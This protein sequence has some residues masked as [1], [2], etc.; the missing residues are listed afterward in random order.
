MITNS[1]PWQLRQRAEEV[2]AGGAAACDVPHGDLR[3]L[4]QELQLHQIELELQNEALREAQIETDAL[5]QRYFELFEHS[6]VAYLDLTDDARILEANRAAANLLGETR[7]ELV[8]QR[9]S[10]FIDAACAL[11]FARYQRGM[12]A[13]DAPQAC[14][15]DIVRADGARRTV[16]IESVR[17]SSGAGRRWR[18]ALIDITQARRVERE[19]RVVQQLEAAG[20]LATA[21][22]HDFDESVSAIAALAQCAL[23][24][25]RAGEGAAGTLERLL[26]AAH[27]AGDFVTQLRVL[28]SNDAGDTASELDRSV[29]RPAA[30]PQAAR[31]G[32]QLQEVTPAMPWP[33]EVPAPGCSTI[34][35]VEDEALIRLTIRNYLEA[36]GHR[37]LEAD[38]MEQAAALLGSTRGGIDLLMS[39]LLLGKSVCGPEL[40][41]TALRLNPKTAVLFMSAHPMRELFKRGWVQVGTP[42][43][44]KPFTRAQLETAVRV[45]LKHP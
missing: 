2:L 19:L 18:A 26:Q 37:V 42:V 12:L 14:E 1:K 34:L 17:D 39:D 38:S 7:P 20:L 32:A 10:R 33:A 35:L 31:N 43:L 4:V 28:A 27:A 25:V 16:R 13:S 9:L 11:S 6:P 44:Q 8:G 3:T 24:Q 41:Q 29:S 22:A 5:R 30:Q 40:A 23:E 21:A 36:L 45:S 15:I